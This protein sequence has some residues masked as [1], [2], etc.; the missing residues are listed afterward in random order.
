M[1]R[2]DYYF[3]KIATPQMSDQIYDWS[4]MPPVH[5][6]ILKQTNVIVVVNRKQLLLGDKQSR[7]QFTI[8]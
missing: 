6:P 4:D 1:Y 3:T 5:Q 7:R 8:A 2:D